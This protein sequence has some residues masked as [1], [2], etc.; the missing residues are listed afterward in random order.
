M[1]TELLSSEETLNLNTIEDEM[2]QSALLQAETVGELAALIVDHTHSEIMQVFEQLP[3]PQQQ[4]LQELW[5]VD[6]PE[7]WK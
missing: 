6:I 4:Q 3:S 7:R 5:G 1:V 2:L